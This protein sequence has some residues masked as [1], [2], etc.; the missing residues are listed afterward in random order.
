MVGCQGKTNLIVRANKRATLRRSLYGRGSNFAELPSVLLLLLLLLVV[1]NGEVI[2][3]RLRSEMLK[4]TKLLIDWQRDE[5]NRE[6]ERDGGRLQT[7][8]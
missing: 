4:V 7:L 2:V 6:G 8:R 5:C 3:P 1:M